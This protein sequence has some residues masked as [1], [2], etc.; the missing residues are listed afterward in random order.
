MEQEGPE[1][2]P[3]WILPSSIQGSGMVETWAASDHSSVAFRR[4]LRPVRSPP[5]AGSSLLSLSL[6]CVQLC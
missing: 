6:P 4:T 1:T 5:L 3:P 2:I